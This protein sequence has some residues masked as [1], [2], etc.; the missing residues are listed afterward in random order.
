[1]KLLT[2]KSP[3]NQVL[4]IKDPKLSKTHWFRTNPDVNGQGAT[5]SCKDAKD[6]VDPSKR[7]NGSLDK[8]ENEEEI[9]CAGPASC[10]SPPEWQVC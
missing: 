6:G 5:G 8:E 3:I 2:P 1:M 10:F 4:T 9:P 7:R